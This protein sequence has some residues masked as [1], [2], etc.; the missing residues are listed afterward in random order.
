MVLYLLS[1]E[2]MY[3]YQMTGV[4]PSLTYTYRSHYNLYSPD[5]NNQFYPLSGP[6]TPACITAIGYREEYGHFYAFS[7][8][9]LYRFNVKNKF[10]DSF[11]K[12]PTPC[13]TTVTAII[14]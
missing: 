14:N 10:W 3:E 1:D 8:K 7:G 6:P 11:G 5:T 2:T 13:D 12:V 9:E 4:L